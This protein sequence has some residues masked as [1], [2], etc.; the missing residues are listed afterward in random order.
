MSALYKLYRLINFLSLDVAAGAVVCALFFAKVFDVH[1]KPVGLVSL[2]LTVWIIYTADNLL[3]AKR[4]LLSASTE[5]HRFH[6]R[7]FKILNPILV[8][9]ILIDVIQIFFIRKPV[10]IG[11]I[12]LAVLVIVYFFVQRYL[13]YFKEIFGAFLYAG[14]VILAPLSLIDQPV[15][16]MQIMLML[17]FALT[18]LINLLLFTW[19]DRERDQQDSHQSFTTI[20]GEK[21]TQTILSIL[22]I[23]NASL[24]AIQLKNGAAIPAVILMLMNVILLFILLNKKYFEVNDR[25]RLLGDAV[26]LLPII[27][28]FM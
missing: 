22:F 2:G 6:Q 15:T 11:G 25:Y 7:Y 13:V 1:I 17:Q 19:F 5:R 20:F 27:Y 9:A 16:P 8:V 23:L 12:V 24:T 26:F 10:I 21:A 18:A 3:D 28:L 4:I 14:G